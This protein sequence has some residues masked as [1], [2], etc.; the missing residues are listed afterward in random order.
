MARIILLSIFL[1]VSCQTPE[2]AFRGEQCSP[3]I[4]TPVQDLASGE[5]FI[6]VKGSECNCRQYRIDIQG[7]GP[8]RN[9]DGTV[10]VVTKPLVECNLIKGYKPKY[11]TKL[12]SVLDWWRRKIK[13]WLRENPDSDWERKDAVSP[14]GSKDR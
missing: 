2:N 11:D 7:V 8:V 10:S 4:A 14:G 9:A 13:D 6:P 12:I 1:L 5:W 3:I